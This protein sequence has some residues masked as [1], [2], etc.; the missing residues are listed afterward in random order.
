MDCVMLLKF[1]HFLLKII[2]EDLLLRSAEINK[3]RD[4]VYYFSGIHL[5]FIELWKR[6]KAQTKE[7]V[8]GP[9]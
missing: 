5:S 7:A 3:S 1:G 6:M 4:Y 2:I 8:D 9:S